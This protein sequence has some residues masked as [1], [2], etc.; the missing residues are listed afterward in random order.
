MQSNRVSAIFAFDAI[1]LPQCGR[2]SYPIE[3]N[4]ALSVMTALDA[5]SIRYC[6]HLQPHGGTICDSR[7]WVGEADALSATPASDAAT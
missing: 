1:K 7:V 4:C 6:R 2:N 3:P 5:I